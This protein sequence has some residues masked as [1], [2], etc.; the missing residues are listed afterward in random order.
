MSDNGGSIYSQQRGIFDNAPVSLWEED[1]SQLKI[2]LDELRASGVDDLSAYLDQNPAVVFDCMRRVRVVD[3]NRKTLEMFKARDK[4]HLLDNLGDVF[5]DEMRLH[6]RDELLDMWQGKLAYDREGVNY[7]LDGQAIFIHLFWSV[8]PGFE[9]NWERVL[10]S[11]IDMTA[12]RQA[13]TRLQESESHFHGLFENAPV[14]LWEEDYS[15]LKRY[16]DD[17]RFAGVEDLGS[18]LD[19]HPQEID[20]AMRKIRVIDV[21]RKTLSLFGAKSKDELLA[22]LPRVFRN[23]MR[24]HFRDE[25]VD[26][27]S[28]CLAYER[29]GINYSLVGDPIDVQLH[30]M[31]Y[32]GYER[33]WERVLVSLEDIT[34]RK[35]A[36]KYLQYLGTHDVLTGLYNR[37]YWDET[38]RRLQSD[39]PFPLSVLEIDL[40]GLKEINDSRGHAAGDDLLRRAGEILQRAFRSQDV[41]ARIGGD[42]FSVFMPGV[43]AREVE[44]KVTELRK[45]IEFNNAF[46]P[47]PQL[48]MSIGM[49]T[50]TAPGML[51]EEIERLADSRMYAEKR[52]RKLV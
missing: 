46:Y 10:V 38:R 22:G 18:Y 23:G 43:D 20:A 6:F 9:T 44:I 12:R 8:F 2:F 27:W 33:T 7:A 29:E 40:D 19:S 24:L 34:A 26:M 14:S 15:D 5:R 21:N 16:L 35:R 41:V 50:C 28:G 45:L 25:L 30:W 3:V 52:N 47:S 42:E 1:Y 37:A 31:V 4:A 51:L 32:P 11:L 36:E 39:G 13:E 17:L 48:S 49:A